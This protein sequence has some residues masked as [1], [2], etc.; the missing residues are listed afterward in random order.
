M[1]TKI[2]VFWYPNEYILLYGV[3]LLLYLI[4]NDNFIKFLIQVLADLSHVI[5]F[6]HGLKQ[7]LDYSN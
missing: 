6:N 5:I 3:I 1:V 7:S 4:I 2:E